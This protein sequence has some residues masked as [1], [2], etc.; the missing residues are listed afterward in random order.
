MVATSNS[1]KLKTGFQTTFFGLI[2]FDV[3][4]LRLL[5][6]ICRPGHMYDEYVDRG[7]DPV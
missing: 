4:V 7:I 5:E 3:S 2:I 1:K 6:R